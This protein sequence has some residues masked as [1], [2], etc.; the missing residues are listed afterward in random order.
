MRNRSGLFTLNENSR[1]GIRSPNLRNFMNT[2][3]GSF[4][5]SR[6]DIFKSRE[7]N[8]NIKGRVELRRPCTPKNCTSKKNFMAHTTTSLKKAV[9]KRNTRSVP[10]GSSTTKKAKLFNTGNLI[11]KNRGIKNTSGK[12]FFGE[13]GREPRSS[14]SIQKRIFTSPRSRT[15]SRSSKQTVFSNSRTKT[16]I[17]KLNSQIQS[18]TNTLHTLEVKKTKISF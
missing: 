11:E 7:S 6:N 1:L 18:I 3:D 14:S 15:I 8:N 13:K 17:S 9:L 10:R 2:H 12:I 16:L 4:R 5:L